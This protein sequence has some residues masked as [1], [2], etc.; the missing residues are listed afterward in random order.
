MAK[1][2]VLRTTMVLVFL[3]GSSAFAA[4]PGRTDKYEPLI[5]TGEVLTEMA[6]MIDEAVRSQ[7]EAEVA[8]FLVL[9]KSGR[10]EL[11][12]WKGTEHARKQSFT[13]VIPPRTIGVV[14]THPNEWSR[15]S[16][17]DLREAR[18]IGLPIYVVTRWD[19]W[20]AEP[21]GRALALVQNRDW[22]DDLG[23]FPHT[24]PAST[25]H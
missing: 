20:V 24:S 25:G 17:A 18:R 23:A 12:R 2:S 16:P 10:Y 3:F 5:W 19:I 15:P 6:A 7:K 13:G 22:R 1:E 21:D 8:A 14:H 9:D 11:R 4:E